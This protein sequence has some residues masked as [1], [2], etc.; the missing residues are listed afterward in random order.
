MDRNGGRGR[1]TSV[2]IQL[3]SLASREASVREV[4]SV[5]VSVSI[6]LISLA[7]RETIREA[8]DHILAQFPF[9]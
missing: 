6:Q 4:C 2:S 7:S 8:N 1:R 3:I 9:N 5:D